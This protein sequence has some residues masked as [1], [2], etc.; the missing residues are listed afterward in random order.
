MIWGVGPQ[1]RTPGIGVQ[2]FFY[3]RHKVLEPH[4]ESLNTNKEDRTLHEEVQKKKVKGLG[5]TPKPFFL[6]PK[7]LQ[8][9]K[10]PQVPPGKSKYPK[11]DFPRPSTLN[12]TTYKPQSLIHRS[13]FGL[14][15]ENGQPAPWTNIA[16][17]P[18]RKRNEGCICLGLIWAL[19]LGVLV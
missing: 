17:L 11:L 6:D 19:G 9:L 7:R 3:A 2:N 5:Y 13:R 12:P 8:P 16:K 4:E 18:K 1:A 10:T 15:V 14:L